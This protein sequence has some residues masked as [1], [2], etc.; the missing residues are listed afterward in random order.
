[1]GRKYSKEK[2]KI[3]DLNDRKNIEII[4]SD[5]IEMSDDESKA[6]KESLN[7]R[8]KQA[9]EFLEYVIQKEIEEMNIISDEEFKLMMKEIIKQHKILKSLINKKEDI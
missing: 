3:I 6:F 8:S 9:E 7:E 2:A 5:S 1:M 4:Q